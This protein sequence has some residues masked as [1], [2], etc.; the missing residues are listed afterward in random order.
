MSNKT[1]ITSYIFGFLIIYSWSKTKISQ[2]SRYLDEQLR[3]VQLNIADTLIYLLGFDEGNKPAGTPL[4]ELARALKEDFSTT[5]SEAVS[6]AFT[7]A[8]WWK[9]RRNSVFISLFPYQPSLVSFSELSLRLTKPQRMTEDMFRALYDSQ[10]LD[11][12]ENQRKLILSAS[13]VS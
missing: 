12:H 1:R 11:K 2:T 8:K 9:D 5:D 10:S 7:V 3:R 13:L 4:V 6:W